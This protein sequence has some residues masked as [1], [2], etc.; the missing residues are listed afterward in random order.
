MPRAD[1]TASSASGKVRPETSPCV[2]GPSWYLAGLRRIVYSQAYFERPARACSFFCIGRRLA[3]AGFETD[4]TSLLRCGLFPF[5][6]CLCFV[7]TFRSAAADDFR[8][9]ARQQRRR[10]QQ[11]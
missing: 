11:G 8:L 9:G 1:A 2:A 3:F 6:T 5:H 7:A 10:D 4:E